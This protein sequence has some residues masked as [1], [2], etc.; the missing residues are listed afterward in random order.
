MPRYFSPGASHIPSIVRSILDSSVHMHLVEA[1]HRPLP[2]VGVQS[3][4]AVLDLAVSQ[5]PRLGLTTANRPI[6]MVGSGIYREIGQRNV[7]AVAS[8]DTG[9]ACDAAYTTLT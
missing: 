1:N 6:K 4:V 2:T 8:G 7:P 3:Q 9:R 5:R